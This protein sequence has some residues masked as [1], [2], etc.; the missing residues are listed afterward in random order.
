MVAVFTF[1]GSWRELFGPL[2]YLTGEE[3]RTLPLGLLYFTS[4]FGSSLPMLMA[5]IVISLIPPVVLYAL[6]QKY[7]DKGMAVRGDGN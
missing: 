1:L 2:I 4:P 6:G 5:A 3:N 7:I